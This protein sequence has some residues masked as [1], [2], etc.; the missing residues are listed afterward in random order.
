MNLRRR[1]IRDGRRRSSTFCKNEYAV[2]NDNVWVTCPRQRYR[3]EVRKVLGGK[4]KASSVPSLAIT[5]DMGLIYESSLIA[6]DLRAAPR[7][8]RHGRH[9]AAG[10]VGGSGTTRS[11]STWTAS[12]SSVS[13]AGCTAMSSWSRRRTGAGRTC[14]IR[15]GIGTTMTALPCA[16]GLLRRNARRNDKPAITCVTCSC[17]A[18]RSLLLLDR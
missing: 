6:N 4:I 11:T 15:R 5:R 3:F 8:R 14:P 9:R 1:R 12:P 18:D 13:S 10:R 2:S 7:Q 16:T 17:H